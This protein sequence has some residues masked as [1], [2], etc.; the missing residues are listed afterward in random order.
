MSNEARNIPWKF[1][2]FQD[3]LPFA[4]LFTDFLS[5]FNYYEAGHLYWAICIWTLMWLPLV[6]SMF[7]ELFNI[8]RRSIDKSR[9]QSSREGNDVEMMTLSDDAEKHNKSEPEQTWFQKHE[10]KIWKFLAQVPFLQP[11]VHAL[12]THKLYKAE[13]G[14]NQ[15]LGDYKKLDKEQ[16]GDPLKNKIEAAAKKYV[17]WKNKK[18]SIL[19]GNQAF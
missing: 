10:M 14:I 2:F 8:L 6:L 1:I 11:A 19:T 13:S 4:D 9:R 17:H 5:G 18:S 3:L 7:A 12:F 16:I 15:A